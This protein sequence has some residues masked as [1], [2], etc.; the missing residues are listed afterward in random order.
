[1]VWSNWYARS[2]GRLLVRGVTVKQPS[3]RANEVVGGRKGKETDYIVQV[4]DSESTYT[5]NNAN[6]ISHCFVKGFM[7]VLREKARKNPRS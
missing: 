4:S 6:Q 5:D 2:P 7:N 1:M 3:S